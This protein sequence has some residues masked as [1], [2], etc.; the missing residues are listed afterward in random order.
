MMIRIIKVNRMLVVTA[1]VGAALIASAWVYGANSW[2]VTGEKIDRF[3]AKV[4][5]I[6]CELGGD[7]PANC[8]D[9]KRQ[10]G[11]LTDD[12]KLILVSKNA[13]AFTGAADELID[14]CNKKVTADGLWAENRGV[15]FFAI[16]FVREVG[17][18]WRA[19]NR[20][21]GKWSKRTGIEESKAG[22]WFRH[23]PRIKEVLERKGLLGIGAE[24]DKKF[25]E[26][27]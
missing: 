25:L 22:N 16:Q 6:A 27:R 26:S 14:F 24:A 20:F 19:A 10:L 21:S 9:G 2:G 8:G 3:D 1:F 7:C 13:T 18:E 12:G 15:R 23:D 11:L 17:G 4:V 5:D